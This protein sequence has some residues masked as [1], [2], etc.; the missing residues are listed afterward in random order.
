MFAGAVLYC[1]SRVLRIEVVGSGACYTS[2]VLAL[3][4]EDGTGFF[5]PAPEGGAL[6]A[7]I[8]SLPRVSFC[9]LRHEGG[10]LTVQVELSDDALPLSSEPLYA[11]ADGVVYALTVVA[12]RALVAVGDSVRAGDVVAENGARATIA[13]V[14]IAYAV[15]EIYAGSE[16]AARAQAYLDHGDIDQLQTEQT[17]SGWRITGEARVTASRNLG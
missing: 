3:L 9:S 1:Q 6:T 15:D 17:G 4:A 13:G 7:R 14:T 8:L 16:D 10:V 2:E 5:S 12:G 11:P